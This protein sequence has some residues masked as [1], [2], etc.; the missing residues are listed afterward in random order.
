MERG[1]ITEYDTESF[2]EPNKIIQ[3]LI[4]NVILKAVR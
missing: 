2:I 3:Q 4:K 1:C